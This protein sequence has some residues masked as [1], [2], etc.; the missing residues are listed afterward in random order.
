ME[1]AIGTHIDT[2]LMKLFPFMF[3]SLE[4][5]SEHISAACDFPNYDDLSTEDKVKFDL[6][7]S[8]SINSLYWMYCKLHAI[9]AKSVSLSFVCLLQSNG[10]LISSIKNNLIL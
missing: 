3:Q 7:L 4:A 2:H 1:G 6:Y 5:I 8:Y 9:D 10:T